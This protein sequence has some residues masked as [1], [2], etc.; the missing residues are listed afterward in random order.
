MTDPSTNMKISFLHRGNPGGPK[1]TIREALLL[2][3]SMIIGGEE[4][5]TLSKALYQEALKEV[6]K[7]PD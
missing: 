7:L 4:H 3:N 2:M 6:E 1:A 5:S